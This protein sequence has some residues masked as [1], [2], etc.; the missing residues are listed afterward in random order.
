MPR[1]RRAREGV[2]VGV[3]IGIGVAIVVRCSPVQ[4]LSCS[5]RPFFNGLLEVVATGV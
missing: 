3:R 5:S 4:L 2:A 1:F